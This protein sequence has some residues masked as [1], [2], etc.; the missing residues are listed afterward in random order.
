MELVFDI[1][2]IV[3][4]KHNQQQKANQ[5]ERFFKLLLKI[6]LLQ[7]FQ[8]NFSTPKPWLFISFSVISRKHYF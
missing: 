1:A 2:N 8:C 7:R 6:N 3:N 5:S 4:Q